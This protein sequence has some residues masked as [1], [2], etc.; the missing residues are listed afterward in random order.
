MDFTRL[1]RF[2]VSRGELYELYNGYGFRKGAMNY[3][4]NSEWFKWLAITSTFSH[5]DAVNYYP[6]SGYVP[7]LGAGQNGNVGVTLRLGPRLRL[8]QTYLYSHLQ[9]RTTREFPEPLT[10]YTNHIAR[11]KVNY[12]FTPALSFRAILDYNGVLPNDT[13]V[14]YERTKRLGYDLLMTY[15]VHPG[16]AL[17]LGYTDIYQNLALD[18]SRPPYLQLSPFPDVNTGRQFFVK[19][20]YLFRF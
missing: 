15:L 1:T 5:G 4:F 16:T 2:T 9:T 13:L 20:S 18:P 7:F 14:R 12:Q 3:V 8:D 17:Y 19:V 10:V 6:G 11:S